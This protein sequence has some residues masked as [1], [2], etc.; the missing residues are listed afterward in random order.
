VRPREYFTGRWR[1]VALG[2]V[3]IIAV[4]SIW[5]VQR[6]ETLTSPA[7]V[8]NRTYIANAS[9]ALAQT[10][11]GTVI[12]SDLVPVPVMVG[13][14]GKNAE[15]SAV[16]APLSHRGGEVS[17]TAQPAG[18][19][20]LLKIFGADGRL[21]P[22]AISG[23]TAVPARENR[24]LGCRL[25]PRNGQ[26]VVPFPAASS[27]STDVL[28]VAYIGNSASN[29]ESLTVAYGSTVSQLPLRSGL[30]NGYITVQGSASDV[31]LEA[32]G[33]TSICVGTIV[34][35]RFVAAIGNGIPAASS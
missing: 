8:I 32:P 7:G 31:I 34:A 29:G 24:K 6:F 9:A 26:L 15:T 30:N 27:P 22:A 14:F 16:L 3:A 17:F 13:L 12:V 35:G 11:P 25:L 1:A 19:I 2:M 4:G 33:T 18:N 20:G 5:S 21:Y 23:S 28:R 10:P